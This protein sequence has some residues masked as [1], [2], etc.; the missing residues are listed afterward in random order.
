MAQAAWWRG[1][2]PGRARWPPGPPGLRLRLPFGDLLSSR[3]RNF[4]YIFSR[5]FPA[6]YLAISCVFFL[7]CFCQDKK[8]LLEMSSCGSSGED[9]MGRHLREVQKDLNQRKYVDWATEEEIAA[10]QAEMERS[11]REEVKMVTIQQEGDP[12]TRG[13]SSNNPILVGFVNPQHDLSLNLSGTAPSL[14]DQRITSTISEAYRITNQLCEDFRVLKVQVEILED[15][16]QT[17]RRIIRDL[18]NQ[19]EQE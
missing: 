6:L 14:E 5:I 18:K 16:N 13:A 19:K 7:I 10:R 8:L 12:S 17:L 9:F 11:V 3:C 15:E 2:P 1:P 4:C